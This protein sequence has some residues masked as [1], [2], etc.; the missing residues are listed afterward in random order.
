MG[1]VHGDLQRSSE[2]DIR[3]LPPASH[4]RCNRYAMFLHEARPEVFI[5]GTR[6]DPSSLALGTQ[7]TELDL[8]TQRRRLGLNVAGAVRRRVVVGAAEW[9]Y[10]VV[11]ATQ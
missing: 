5:P 11:H 9:T 2:T 1:P 8:L 6:S 10:E 3:A 7:R 4:G